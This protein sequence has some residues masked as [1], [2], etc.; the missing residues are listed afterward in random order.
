MHTNAQMRTKSI[1]TKR[2]NSKERSIATLKPSSIPA[3]L[4]LWMKAEQQSNCFLLSLWQY[5]LLK[6][7]IIIK[8]KSSMNDDKT[9]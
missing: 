9:R 5:K 6:K 2:Q 4:L 1:D 8:L 3:C 7:I